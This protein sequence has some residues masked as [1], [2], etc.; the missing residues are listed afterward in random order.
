MARP[1]KKPEEKLSAAGRPAIARE[2]LDAFGVDAVIHHLEEYSSLTKLAKDVGV[3]FGALQNWIESDPERAARV[4]DCRRLMARKWDERAE[5]E[6][7]KAKDQFE[8]NKAREIAHHYRWRA[9]KIAPEYRDK[10][11]IEMTGKDGGPIELAEKMDDATLRAR[12]AELA[13]KYGFAQKE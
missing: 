9:A 2:A 11:D 4:R 5:A 12:I 8:L 7:R 3:A 1:Y 10:K 6:I 13:T